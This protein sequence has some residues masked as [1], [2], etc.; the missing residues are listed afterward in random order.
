MSLGERVSALETSG[1]W[2]GGNYIFEFL[3]D[4]F[5]YQEY[6]F[7]LLLAIALCLVWVGGINPWIQLVIP[8]SLLRGSPLLPRSLR[9]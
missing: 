7:F 6:A 2:P 3:P 5:H 4:L 9:N 1:I 8:R